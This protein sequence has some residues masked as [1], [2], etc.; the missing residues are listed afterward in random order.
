MS[1][2]GNCLKC[3]HYTQSLLNLIEG[4]N[5][6]EGLGLDLGSDLCGNIKQLMHVIRVQ[7]RTLSASSKQSVSK[8]KPLTV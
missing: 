7:N 5:K 3:R 1:E 4:F 8:A 6:S 2:H